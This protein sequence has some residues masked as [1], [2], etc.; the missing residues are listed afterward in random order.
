[1]AVAPAVVRADLDRLRQAVHGRLQ[2]DHH[3]TRP[4]PR[5]LADGLQGLLNGLEPVRG[6]AAG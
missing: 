3:V 4:R 5:Q 1:M 2:V 6:V